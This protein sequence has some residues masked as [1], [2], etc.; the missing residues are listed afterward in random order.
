[1]AQLRQ[2]VRAVADLLPQLGELAAQHAHFKLL[3]PAP[4]LSDQLL[5]LQRARLRQHVLQIRDGRIDLVVLLP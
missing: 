4:H 1:V 2:L 5:V 3:L